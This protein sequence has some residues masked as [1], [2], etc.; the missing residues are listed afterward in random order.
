MIIAGRDLNQKEKDFFKS[1]KLS[2]VSTKIAI[3]AL[4]FITNKDNPIEN[5]TFNELRD[6]FSGKIT[7]WKLLDSSVKEKS[8]QDTSITIVFDNEK[9]C[10]VRIPL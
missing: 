8:S 2:P 3:D 9:S 6:V 4:A 7:G 1:Q 5:L 10:N